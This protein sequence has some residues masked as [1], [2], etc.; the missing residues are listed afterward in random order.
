MIYN[1]EKHRVRKLTTVRPL[2]T[3]FLRGGE[4]TNEAAPPCRAL[5]VTTFFPLL[6]EKLKRKREREREKE[7]ERE[8]EREEREKNLSPAIEWKR[9][10][11]RGPF[12][13]SS[14]T[15]GRLL[16]HERDNKLSRGWGREGIARGVHASPFAPSSTFSSAIFAILLPRILREYFTLRTARCVYS[17]LVG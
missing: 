8:R 5:K 2:E 13:C 9:G 16:A 12:V 17:V 6:T 7:R 15:S 11:R 14:I 4:Y 10:K 1:P 3:N